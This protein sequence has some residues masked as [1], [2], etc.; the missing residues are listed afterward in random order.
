MTDDDF[1]RANV[2]AVITRSDGAVL[3]LRRADVVAESWQLPQGGI[4]RGEQAEDALRR[5]I[6]EEVGLTPNDYII[7][8]HSAEWLAYELPAEFRS[9]KTG[10]GQA[11]MWFHC[12]LTAPESRIVLDGIEFDAMSWLPP[13][14]LADNA[15]S[16][17]RRIYRRL[18]DEFGLE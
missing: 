11:Q 3:A 4:G 9:P 13:R 8:G 7:V 10:R 15:V 2:G 12:R 14:Q 16:F 1:F 18:I 5:E 17:R 6:E